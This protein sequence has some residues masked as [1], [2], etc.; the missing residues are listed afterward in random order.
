LNHLP[1]RP[2]K[3]S[4]KAEVGIG[5]ATP[6]ERSPHMFRVLDW[7]FSG[8]AEPVVAG[9]LLATLVLSIVFV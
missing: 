8:T 5:P 6:L 3:T 1:L 7:N 2:V 9:L 4:V